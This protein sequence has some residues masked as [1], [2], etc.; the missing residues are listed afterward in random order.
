MNMNIDA[1]S[2]LQQDVRARMSSVL[3]NDAENIL[4]SLGLNGATA[5]KMLYAQIVDKKGL[6][7][8]PTLTA[9]HEIPNVETRRAM[10]LAEAKEL[11]MIPDDSPRFSSVSELMEDL[12]R[13]D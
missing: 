9:S 3:K 2:N 6:P 7:F 10:V 4:S 8:T 5:I 13:E 1:D 12:G 11:G